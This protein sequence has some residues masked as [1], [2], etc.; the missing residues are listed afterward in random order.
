M[1]VQSHDPIIES[2]RQR[3]NEELSAM[4][5]TLSLP[6]NAFPFREIR[7]AA[8]ASLDRIAHHLRRKDVFNAAVST[9]QEASR[10]Y[11]QNRVIRIGC[12]PVSADPFHWG[13]LLIGLNA[14]A[15]FELDKVIYVLAGSDERKPGITP[16]AIRH[17]IGRTILNMFTPLFDYL[18]RGGSG[19]PDGESSLFKLLALNRDQ[20]IDAFYIAG[21]DHCRRVDPATGNADT[22]QKLE[23]NMTNGIYGFNDTR[24][25][26]FPIFV[27]RGLAAC[28]IKTQLEVSFMPGLPFDVSSTAIR[29]AFAGKEEGD[30]LAF[31]P[32]TAYLYIRALGLYTTGESTEQK[33]RMLPVKRAA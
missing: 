4:A 6:L 16:P 18:P 33:K 12:Y 5:E 7:A 10:I 23:D 21:S 3:I 28:R 13:H 15:R 9:S 11:V 19:D 27:K 29:Q 30:K 22:V 24:H 1:K 20:M 14:M 2:V 31:L 8:G 17:P 25:R 32:H 26:V